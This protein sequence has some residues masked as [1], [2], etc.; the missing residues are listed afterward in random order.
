MPIN[1]NSTFLENT[2]T[3]QNQLH[4]Y[5][6]SRYPSFIPTKRRLISIGSIDDSLEKKIFK[7]KSF[8][9]KF[10][11]KLNNLMER[12]K[13]TK[14]KRKNQKKVKVLKSKINTQSSNI[15]NLEDIG[16]IDGNMAV[17]NSVEIDTINSFMTQ[18]S[19]YSVKS[20]PDLSLPSPFHP[21][22]ELTSKSFP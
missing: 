19:F 3:L 8:V 11:D 17:G 7:K 6:T 4:D 1:P 14:N 22:D 5:G 9:H 12:V 18:D 15:Y 16:T 21:T 2:T 13:I 10:K 20:S